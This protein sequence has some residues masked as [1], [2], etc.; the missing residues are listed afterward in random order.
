MTSNLKKK[1]EKT[2]YKPINLSTYLLYNNEIL[3]NTPRSTSLYNYAEICIQLQPFN[4]ILKI[5][6]FNCSYV[7]LS[8]HFIKNL[9]ME[10]HAFI[11]WTQD[12]TEFEKKIVIR[13]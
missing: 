2:P 11:N 8:I 12:Q 3:Q 9:S 13:N 4:C 5:P 7:V 10:Y 6:F 1:K